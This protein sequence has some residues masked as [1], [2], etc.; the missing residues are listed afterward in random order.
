MLGGPEVGA[1]AWVG[2]VRVRGVLATASQSGLLAILL[3]QGRVW[4]ADSE[5]WMRGVRPGQPAE[6]AR[7]LC[8][9]ASWAVLDSA[10]AN[11]RLATVWDMLAAAAAVVE[12]DPTGRPQACAAWTGEAPPLVE[13]AALRQECR[14]VFPQATLAAG[15]G[16]SRLA[17]RLACPDQGVGVLKERE[18]IA[19]R[20]A[21][22]PLELLVEESLVRPGAVR[23]L[24]AL[25]A[26]N[27]GQVAALPEALVRARLGVEGALV[28]AAC[29]GYDDRPVYARH[30]PRAVAV[31]ARYPR[32]L[33][34]RAWGMAAFALAR[35][36]VGRLRPGEGVG[37]LVLIAGAEGNWR[38]TWPAPC[39]DGGV[40]AR[41]ARLLGA[42]AAAGG[43]EPVSRLEVRLA[44]LAWHSPRARSLLDAAR[45]RRGDALEELLR[46]LPRQALQRGALGCDD[47]EVLLGLLDP[48]RGGR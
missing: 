37:E 1:V 11:R 8:P 47:Y 41:A 3:H 29:R 12:P 33:P 28:H 2:L 15:L 46:R 5:A 20:L 18:E 9:Q 32:E 13:V 35:R 23:T 38:R 10:A 6:E 21:P 14:R 4:D 45:P 48:L 40:L 25:G 16:P 26:V 36:A 43:G 39:M 22:R 30:P 7:T 19:R 24:A 34:P 42:R 17:A 44:D 27:C 31:Q